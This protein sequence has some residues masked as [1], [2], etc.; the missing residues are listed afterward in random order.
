M[1]TL[2][3]QVQTDHITNEISRMFDYQFDGQTEF[4]LP[5]F[6]KPTQDFNIGSVSYTH[7][8]LPTIYSV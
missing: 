7:L 8:T 5:E 1:V 2:K 4:T 6:Q 3:S